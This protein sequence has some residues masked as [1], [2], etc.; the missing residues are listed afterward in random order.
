MSYQSW[1]SSSAALAMFIDAI[2]MPLAMAELP[3]D[4]RETGYT[5]AL[6]QV[7]TTAPRVARLSGEARNAISSA[8]A[9][10]DTQRPCSASGI[11]ARLAG[12]SRI[13]GAIALTQIFLAGD[14]LAE[15]LGQHAAT[16]LPSM[17]CRRSHAGAEPWFQRRGA[18]RH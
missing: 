11:A 5:P 10:G 16:T 7:R 1:N 8:A 12:V 17:R 2:R 14:F 9:P 13:D 4:C 6:D 15:R 18:P 3:P